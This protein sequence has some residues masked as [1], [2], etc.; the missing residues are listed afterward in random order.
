MLT[1]AVGQPQT[2]LT[3][4]PVDLQE[5]QTAFKSRATQVK[6]ATAMSPKEINDLY[7]AIEERVAYDPQFSN[8]PADAKAAEVERQ[9][10]ESMAR[11]SGGGQASAA[12]T[13][14]ARMN[15]FVEALRRLRESS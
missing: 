13:P 11:A 15:A 4:S 8:L 3:Y 6:P 9:F 7:Q 2:G 10:A 5:A 14:E 12:S 1:S